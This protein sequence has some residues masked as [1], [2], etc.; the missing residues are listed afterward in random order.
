[1]FLPTTREEMAALGWKR[2]DAILV[3]G[4]SYADVPTAG[5]ALV[6]KALI[7]AGYRV[8][9]IAQP[10]VD[11]MADIRRLG[12]P[13]LFWGVTAGG[14]D[15]MVAN[16]TAS[17]RRRRSDD[18]TAGGRN[19]RRPDRATIVYANLIRRAFKNT[20]PIVL[21]GIE[22]S[23]RRIAHYDFMS[24]RIRRSVLAD[25]KADWLLYGMAER[26]VVELADCLR[27]GESP[28]SL[29]GL[30]RMARHKP[31]DAVELP[32]F[33][34]AARDKAAFTRMFTLF[35]RHSDPVSGRPL[36]QR[37]DTRWLV[38]NPPALPLSSAELDAVHALDFEREAHPS[39]RAQGPIKALETVRFSL[40]TH[41]GCYGECRF[42]AIAP[43]QGR[44]VVWRSIPSLVA[45]ARSFVAH[46]AFRGV[47]HDAGGPT[48]N[49]Y[50]IECARKAAKGA[51]V[52]KAC[53]FPR[54]CP[55]LPVSH[56]PQLAMLAALR[57]VPGVRK[58]VVASGI[59]HDLV[60]ADR[61]H[62][63]AWL[64]TVARHHVSGQ[65]KLAPEHSETA[66][67]DLMG[68]PDVR[69]LL[70]FRR[71]F[72]ALT[73][74]LDKPQHLTY[75]MVAAHPGCRMEDM[76]RLRRFALRELKL[77]PRQVQIFTPT[78]STWSTLMY[79]TERDPFTGR[80]CYVEKTERGRV[81][82]KKRVQEGTS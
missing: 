58:V 56:A 31:P 34:E 68:K 47:I 13:A 69:S 2:L 25:A 80:P 4:D 29:R 21:G 1:M 76:E 23:L 49:M 61:T 27:R 14:V 51:C 10:D 70:P 59:R 35:W 50:G 74:R 41:R 11:G 63:A 28:E 33:E 55:E 75:Y 45:E 3:G 18:F 48:A 66:I 9:V 60:L 46:P 62:G 54:I 26:S 53:L 12:E 24:D 77:L 19:D 20:V 8:G 32:S 17:G 82:Q 37:Q 6:G 7:A 73:R 42:C 5:I 22:A 39:H 65:M 38:Q 72:Q 79:W 36:A 81:A 40:T 43:H 71:Q 30:C 67:T 64:E 52:G 15:S 57:A 16:W 78:P 44:Q